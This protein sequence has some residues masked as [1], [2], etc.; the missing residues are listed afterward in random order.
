[1]MK[2]KIIL[3]IFITLLFTTC[4]IVYNVS[5]SY[6]LRQLCVE[7][8]GETST[9]CD[10]KYEMNETNVKNRMV[11][12]HL[13]NT[14]LMVSRLSYGAWITFGTQINVDQALASS[15]F[16]TTIT[17]VIGFLSFLVIVSYYFLG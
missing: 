13:G 2:R 15:I 10:S 11:Y 1:M 14:G 16:V 9:I 4:N 5:A 3:T 8:N 7:T 6:P 12:Q 17:D